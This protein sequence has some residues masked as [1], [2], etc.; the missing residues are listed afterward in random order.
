MGAATVVCSTCLAFRFFF[1]CANEAPMFSLREP[2]LGRARNNPATLFHS[3]ACSSDCLFYL[4]WYSSYRGW[5]E[6][7]SLIKMPGTALRC[8]LGKPPSVISM[9][10][11]LNARDGG[12]RCSLTGRTSKVVM[13]GVQPSAILKLD[14]FLLYVLLV[15][16]AVVV[17]FCR[18]INLC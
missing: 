7:H 9:L 8:V 13:C 5:A 15:V 11:R 6:T 3:S 1:S 14:S 17:V 12:S 4:H 10:V 2:W 18:F 16:F